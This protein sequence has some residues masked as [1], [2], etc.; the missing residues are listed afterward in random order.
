LD[1]AEVEELYKSMN[2]F[3]TARSPW[4]VRTLDR[5]ADHSFL[6]FCLVLIVSIGCKLLS[7]HSRELWLDET[8]SAFIAHL[9][10]AQLSSHLTGEYNPPFYYLLLW[11][12]TR[13]VGDAQSQLRL[14]GVLI[15]LCAMAGMYQ[16][17]QRI[18]DKRFG[19]L[20]AALF[21]FSPMLFVYSLEVRSYMLFILAFIALL[22]AHWTLA[23]Q[24]KED[25][26]LI[27][28]YT[29]LA[30]LLFYINYMGV[31]ILMGLCLHWIMAAGLDRR[32]V[33]RLVATGLLTALLI[34]PGISPLLYRN[35]LKHELNHARQA[36]FSN[37]SA[38]SY[39][40]SDQKVSTLRGLVKSAAA[41]AGFY[42][43]SSPLLLFF[44]ALPLVLALAGAI[45]LGLAKNDELCRLFI[46][47]TLAIGIGAVALHLSATRYLLPLVPLL[48]LAVARTIQQASARPRWRIASLTVASLILCFYAAGFFRQTFVRHGHPW[49]N[50]VSA[51]Q[52]N[53]KSGDTVAFSALYAQVPFDYFARQTHF[54][55]REVGFP[56]SIY[57]WWSKQKNQ[58][59]GGPVIL[60]SDL[61][62]F[63]AHLIASDS[64]TL[65]IVRY[66]T[67][68]YDPQDALLA[69]MRQLGKVEEISLPPDPDTTSE[70]E[71]LRLFRVKLQQ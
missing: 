22:E 16:I 68:Y 35:S 27:A 21:A 67:Y 23:I 52:Q 65:W 15:N 47:M 29:M 40:D 50:L 11:A 25:N 39:G 54:Q 3:Q 38:L 60:R 9:P 66:E 53:S 13:M 69:R 48:V 12:W 41:M 58:A 6:L 4:L 31:F 59:W 26:W 18:L 64:K 49:Q 70:E 2:Q 33:V 5:F 34:A 42:P 51:V 20:A 43:A 71:S 61:D 10:F 7:L 28:V 1:G 19:A 62:D 63:A 8:Y 32:R 24:K 57:D 36:S 37:P 14:L 56:L 46:V 17:S 55:P 44:C 30:A 45:Y